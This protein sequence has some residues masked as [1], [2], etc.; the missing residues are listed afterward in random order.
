MVMTKVAITI[1]TELIAQVDILVSQKVFP[2][3]SKAI[4]FAVKSQLVQLRRERLAKELINLD[5]LEEQQ[6][7]DE[8]IWQELALC[9]EY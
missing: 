8:G 5:P 7:A 1:D 4:Q 3:R 6:L 9:P 2:N